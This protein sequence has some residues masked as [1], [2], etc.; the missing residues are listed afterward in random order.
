MIEDIRIKIAAGRFILTLHA[1]LACEKRDIS[2]EEIVQV[3]LDGEV[4]ED[5]PNDKYGPS[6]LIFGYTGTGRPL[7]VQ[8]TYPTREPIRV[9]TTY[10]PDPAKW[11][12]SRIR[13]E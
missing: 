8:T 10:E 12:D 13:R 9:I 5:Y 1:S 11:I 3:I 6:C 4:I 7:H 2:K